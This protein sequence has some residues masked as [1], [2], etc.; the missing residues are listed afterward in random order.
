MK[1]PG[2]KAVIVLGALAAVKVA[3]LGGAWP[4]K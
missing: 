1:L 3:A 4:I 2:N